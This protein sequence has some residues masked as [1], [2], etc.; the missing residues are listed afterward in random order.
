L[1]VGG[2][3]LMSLYVSQFAN[4]N[5]TYGSLGA[6]I[7]LLLW[8]YLSAYAVIAG[9]ELNAVTERQAQSNRDSSNH[10]ADGNG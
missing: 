8:L 4:I 5:K 2:S 3:L 9:A 6:I 1:W 7:L 10:Q